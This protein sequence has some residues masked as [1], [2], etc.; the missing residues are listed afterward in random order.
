MLTWLPPYML[1]VVLMA[2]IALAY[3]MVVKGMAAKPMLVLN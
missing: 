2:A 3:L 1:F